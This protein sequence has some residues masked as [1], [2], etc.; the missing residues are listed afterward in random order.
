MNPDECGCGAGSACKP[1]DATCANCGKACP[2]APTAPET[3]EMPTPPTQ[4]KTICLRYKPRLQ[5]EKWHSEFLRGSSTWVRVSLCSN[6][7]NILM[8]RSALPSFNSMR[9]GRLPLAY[10]FSRKLI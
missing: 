6:R 5:G 8:R 4:S 9:C 2:A 1:G 7:T 10:L 3:P